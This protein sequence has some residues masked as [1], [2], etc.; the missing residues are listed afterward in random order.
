MYSAGT[1]KLTWIDEKDKKVLHSKMYKTLEEALK[2]TQS[3]KNWLIFKL[4]NVDGDNYSWDLLPYGTSKSYQLGMSF[5]DNKILMLSSLT[6]I[7]LG[8]FY[9]FKLLKK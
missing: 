2:D 3:K 9:V 7:G 4:K 5:V 6:L 1:I 8:V